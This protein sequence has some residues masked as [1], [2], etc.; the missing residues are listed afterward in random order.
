MSWGGLEKENE[1]AVAGHTRNVKK[2][3]GLEFSTLPVSNVV[4]NQNSHD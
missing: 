2:G 1:L 4:Q 3:P